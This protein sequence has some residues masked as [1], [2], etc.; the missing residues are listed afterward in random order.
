M[1]SLQK[2]ILYLG[3]ASLLPATLSAQTKVPPTAK[4]TQAASSLGPQ[5]VAIRSLISSG[6]LHDLR[7]PDLSDFRSALDSFYKTSGYQAAW[8]RAGKPSA[9]SEVVIRTLQLADRKGLNPEDYDASRWNERI[10][11]IEGPH[12]SDD[13]AAFDVGLTVCLMRYVTALHVGRINPQ[14]LK[15]ELKVKRSAIDLPKFVGQ[16]RNENTDVAKELSGIE[17]SFRAYQD[18]QGA[19]LSYMDLAKLDYGEELPVPP[20][21]AFPGTEYVGVPLLAKKLRLV[22]DLPK[23]IPISPDAKIYDG[24]LVDAVKRFQERH[25]LMPDGYLNRETIEQI[26]IPPSDRTEQ[27]RLELERYRWIHYDFPRPPVMVN[28]PE[29]RLYALDGNGKIALTMKVNVGDSYDFQTPVLEN[30]IRYLVF[31]PYWN[32]PPNI[33]K[34]E[35]IP[36]IE[37]DRDYVRDNRM[38][39]MTLSGTVVTSETINDQVLQQLRAGKLTVRE[40]PGPENALGLLKFIFPNDHHVYLHDT[41]EGVDMFYGVQRAFSHGCIHVEQPALLAAWLLGDKPGWT[42]ERVE[43]AMEE[44]RDNVTVNLTKPTPILLLYGTVVVQG[45]GKVHFYRDIYGHDAALEKALAKGY[46][47]P[48]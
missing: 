24:P 32:V 10:A 30:D 48:K 41:P 25:G 12:S 18:L 47:Y 21:I 35:V 7:W 19:L 38:E 3:V 23:D 36:D 2:L 40:K 1:N 44:G 39:V 11:H 22:G 20:V 4:Q 27:I 15:F 16:L 5:Q 13:E 17:P 14:H 6:Q 29:F 42:M 8:L 9:Q 34:N 31:R 37:A 28:I 43:Q 46:P 33:L 45:D 26:N